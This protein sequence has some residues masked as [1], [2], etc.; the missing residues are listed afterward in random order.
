MRSRVE[1]K[2]APHLLEPLFDNLAIAPS[3]RSLKE[4]IVIAAAPRKKFPAGSRVKAQIT[5]PRVPMKVTI[6]GV[7]PTRSANLA[8]G[9]ITFV[10]D[11]LSELLIIWLIVGFA[12]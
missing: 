6:F 4:K 1:S 9:L 5:K 2:N 11:G 12:P 10:T 3:K 7:R 8:T